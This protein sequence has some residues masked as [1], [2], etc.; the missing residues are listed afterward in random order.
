MDIV[1]SQDIWTKQVPSTKGHK[2]KTKEIEENAIGTTEGRIMRRWNGLQ[3]CKVQKRKQAWLNL[4]GQKKIDCIV[5]RESRKEKQPKKGKIP[6]GV[7]DGEESSSLW[8]FDFFIFS[9]RISLL[10]SFSMKCFK[11]ENGVEK[12]S[13]VLE[14]LAKKAENAARKTWSQRVT[15]SKW[16]H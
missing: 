11:L 5:I 15:H 14:R 10:F 8:C 12:Y 4:T 13:S 9:D 2:N 6:G 7:D 3:Y 16:T 1:T